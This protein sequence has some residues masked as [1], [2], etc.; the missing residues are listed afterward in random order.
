MTTS[1]SKDEFFRD[2]V[3]CMLL[4]R[5]SECGE[6]S[7]R[8]SQ[9]SSPCN[10][11]CCLYF[12]VNP[13]NF[14]IVALT[15][16]LYSKRLTLSNEPCYFGPVRQPNLVLAD[17]WLLSKHR[18]VLLEASQFRASMRKRTARSGSEQVCVARRV[19]PV[20][21]QHWWTRD[22]CSLFVNRHK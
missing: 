22:V 9:R 13:V 1:F 21:R 6:I 8:S 12:L 16:F 19:R 20:A 2:L 4:Q 15:E 14:T 5:T 11:T 17:V 10:S 3:V 18:L 7:V